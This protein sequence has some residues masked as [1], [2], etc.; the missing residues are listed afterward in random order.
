M[1]VSK[2]KVKKG[3]NWRFV[4]SI[5]DKTS[6]KRKDVC[7]GGFATKPEAR[8]AEAI[9]REQLKNS[10]LSF[11]AESSLNQAFEY[12]V[13]R[14]MK[15]GVKIQTIHGYRHMYSSTFGK[16]FGEKKISQINVVDLQ[17]YVDEITPSYI[18]LKNHISIANSIFDLAFKAGIIRL[19]PV[20]LVVVEKKNLKKKVE[21]KK[22]LTKKELQIF[23]SS[24]EER[25]SKRNFV[26]D[27]RETQDRL[28]FALLALTGMRIGELLAL[29]WEDIDLENQT[30]SINKSQ[31]EI[32]RKIIMSE[33]KTK[34][35]KRILPIQSKYILD[36]L[37]KW[38]Y[39]Q[40]K[41]Q[42]KFDGL[43]SP[44][45]DNLFYNIEKI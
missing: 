14:S 20:A 22:F 40:R 11:N 44:L 35:S 23:F 31:S 15:K 17:D 5:L 42:E 16:R 37:K 9:Y 33:T 38:K 26:R 21:K 29:T 12:W 1:S 10:F 8:L 28:I 43:D 27:E 18:T 39:E 7:R 3:Y 4:I 24:F 19:N 30:I 6:K 36:L 13:E 25:L 41:V 34:S 32:I 45:K 2:Y